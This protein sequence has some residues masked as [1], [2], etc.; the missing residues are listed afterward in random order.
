[1]RETRIMFHVGHKG[2]SEERQTLEA[3]TYAQT[4]TRG[5]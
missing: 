4:T 3:K 5:R 2:P 1:M